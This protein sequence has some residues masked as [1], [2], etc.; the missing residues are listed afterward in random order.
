MKR[1]LQPGGIIGFGLT[2]VFSVAQE[3]SLQE[4]CWSTWLAGLVF[5]WT[6]VVVAAIQ[7]LLT[8]RRQVS[9]LEKKIA[10]LV[11]VRPGILQAA[12]MLAA[13]LVAWLAL[14]AYS[15]VFSFYG[16]FLSVFAEMEPVS[17]FGRNGFINSDFFTPVTYLVTKFWPMAV[18]TLA[19]SAGEFVKGDPWKRILVPAEA[20]VLRMHL[21]ILAL[22][23]LSLLAWALF[24]DAYQRVT[25]VLLCGL[26]FLLGARRKEEKKEDERGSGTGAA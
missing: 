3:W 19:A 5:A 10:R 16:L 2:S 17:L 7:I 8:S 26:F 11:R 14:Y 20:E 21:M 9:R 6:C 12:V 24:G 13:G 23:V 15:F 1:L 4:F 22:P 18:G 25:I